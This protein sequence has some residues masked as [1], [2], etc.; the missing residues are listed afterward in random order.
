MKEWNPSTLRRPQFAFLFWH[1]INATHARISDNKIE[2]ANLGM[3]CEN[4]KANGVS[5]IRQ[6]HFHTFYTL[7]AS[8]LTA[9]IH[10]PNGMLRLSDVVFDG[11]AG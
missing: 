8:S 7:V 2:W 3:P 1:G 4:G 5:V 6:Q 9:R 10:L 11:Y